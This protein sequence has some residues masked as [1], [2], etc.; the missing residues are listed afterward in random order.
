MGQVGFHR[1]VYAFS[2][3][4]SAAGKPPILLAHPPSPRATG[5]ATGEPATLTLPHELDRRARLALS[6][7]KELT[8]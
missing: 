4:W 2:H 7:F 5:K 1:S 6:R 3:V 8:G